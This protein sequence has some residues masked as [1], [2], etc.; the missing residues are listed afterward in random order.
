MAVITGDHFAN[1]NDAL[2]G[3]PEP[4]T[5]HGGEGD[6]T[7]SAG[8]GNDSLFGDN[9]NDTLR[10]EDDN[11]FM[12]GG[13]GND[14]IYGGV[15]N[16]QITDA[17][18]NDTL[19]GGAGFDII[20][21]YGG[22]DK[23]YGRG[24]NDIVKVGI[25]QYPPG[26]NNDPRGAIWD[27]GDGIDELQ[28]YIGLPSGS[29]HLNIDLTQTTIT[30]FE[31]LSFKDY[32]FDYSTYTIDIY[33]KSD[34]YDQFPIYGSDDPLAK[35]FGIFYPSAMRITWHIVDTGEIKLPANLGYGSI[36][37]FAGIS[38][39]IDASKSS[40][41]TTLDTGKGDDTVIGSPSASL[42]IHFGDGSDTLKGGNGTED[43]QW[44]AGDDKL[45][46]GGGDD[47]VDGGLGVDLLTG[48]LGIDTFRFTTAKDSGK[49]KKQA[50]HITDFTRKRI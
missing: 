6:D 19:D 30:G 42:D 26:T 23:I 35:M 47:T 24:D 34:Q 31:K 1:K 43:G 33:I 50:D 15:G 38:D 27:G 21:S 46:G 41:S 3:T 32:P 10:G 39:L 40:G 48:G 36:F 2:G 16:D 28:F 37:E 5:I 18:G 49:S 11:D 8:F 20:T 17:S 12:D 9:G 22:T 7:I 14:T 44:Q 45:N 29:N 4:D 13:T 25:G